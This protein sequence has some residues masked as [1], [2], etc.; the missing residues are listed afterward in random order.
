MFIFYVQLTSSFCP[1]LTRKVV[2]EILKDSSK[3]SRANVI[4]HWINVAEKCMS[5]NNFNAL[6]SIMAAMTSSP[7]RRLAKT[8]DV[9]ASL[10]L[11][12]LPP[13]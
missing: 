10:Y 2:V 5:L 11:L 7:V 4:K 1:Q 8:W 13:L 6:T 12:L 3:K 9:R